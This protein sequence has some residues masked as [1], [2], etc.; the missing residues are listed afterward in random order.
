MNNLALISCVK[1]K[2]IHKAKARNMYKSTLFV[3][4]LR[5]VENVLKPEKIY[6]L[7]AKYGLLNLDQE[8]DS[9]NETI[10]N[11]SREKQCTCQKSGFVKNLAPATP[12]LLGVKMNKY[13][14]IG[15]PNS[16]KTTLGRRAADELRLPFYDT[17]AMVRDRV[18]D[19]LDLFRMAFNGRFLS[20]QI[21]I[22]SELAK[23]DGGAIIATGAEVALIPKCAALMK[24]MGT[25]I[26]IQRNPDILLAEYK[27]SGKHGMV[28][29]EKG[30]KEIDMTEEAI[31]LY[32]QECSHYEAV[33]DLTLENDGSEDE[34]LEKLVRLMGE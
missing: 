9:Y 6:I 10:N 21:K 11:K 22:I 24:T 26:H 27:N 33:A 31:K 1:K 29:Q 34:G 18:T 4:S 13:I 19:P 5:Y 3:K 8:I 7:S 15:I 2:D 16:G 32:A 14:L 23:L 12:R 20:E 30:G 28:M 25:V 17:D